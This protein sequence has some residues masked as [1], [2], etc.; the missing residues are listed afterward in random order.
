MI[1]A[2]IGRREQGKTTLACTMARK[3]DIRVIVDPRGMID[4]VRG[5]HRVT[6]IEHLDVAFDCITDG[7]ESEIVITPDV[8]LKDMFAETCEQLR[9]ICSMNVDFLILRRAKHSIGFCVA[10]HAGQCTFC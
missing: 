6:R 1:Y 8:K 7:V 3:L 10:C 9:T 4:P 2:I 5:S